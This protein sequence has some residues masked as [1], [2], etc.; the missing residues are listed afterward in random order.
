MHGVGDPAEVIG[1]ILLPDAG[2]G[3]IMFKTRFAP[4]FLTK[5]IRYYRL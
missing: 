3:S 1:S 5:F 2:A 4:E